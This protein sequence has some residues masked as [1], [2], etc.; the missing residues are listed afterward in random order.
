MRTF[1]RRSG[2]E[3]GFAMVTVVIALVMLMLVSSLVLTTVLRSQS[4]QRN[5][6]DYD[7]ALQAA[8]AGVDDYISRLN[9]TNGAYYQFNGRTTFDAGNPAMG[10]TAAGKLNWAAVDQ[11]G[12]GADGKGQRGFFHYEVNTDSYTGKAASAS[13][14]AVAANGTLVITS[15]GRVGG[16][17]RTVVSSVRRSGFLD[18]LYYTQ[19]ETKDPFQYPASGTFYNKTWATQNCVDYYESRDPNCGN[20]Q[21]ASDTLSGPV[22]SKDLM[23]IC[24]NVTFNAGVFTD[25]A[26]WNGKYYRTNSCGSTSNQ[27]FLAGAPK[28]AASLDM[29]S[30]NGALKAQTSSA[31]SPQGCLFVGPTRITLKGSKIKVESPWTKSTRAECALDTWINVPANGVVYVDNVPSTTTDPNYW[32]NTDPGKPSCPSV[33]NNLGFPLVNASDS[34]RSESNYTTLDLYGCKV[35]DVFISEEGGLKANAFDGRL[36]VAAKN[37]LIITDNIDYKDGTNGNSLLGLIA[38]RNVWYWHPTD[39]QNRDIS[40]L[41]KGSEDGRARVSAALLSVQHSVG[42]MNPSIGS[43]ST[44][45]SITGNI[46]QEFRGI[47]KNASG[48]QKDY[49][50][51]PRLKYDAPPH[52]LEPTTSSFRVTQTSETS[53]QYSAAS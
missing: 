15:T 46:T 32:K 21:F 13:V 25:H 16:E 36:T 22:Y 45:L 9:S 37:D 26:P 14:P 41:G 2:D 52:F 24:D 48:Y 12:A 40:W 35:G 4:F 28:L 43:F 38:E 39:T 6:Q 30:T 23:L 11:S 31:V 19:Y 10:K 51:D 8:Q 18:N 1:L 50:Y 53:P 29:P 47:V 42:L 20:I 7:A 3:S 5:Q 33:G 27:K 49:L 34:T 17:T 44:T